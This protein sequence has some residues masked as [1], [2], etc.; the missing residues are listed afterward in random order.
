MSRPTDLFAGSEGL[1]AGGK[2]LPDP[3]LQVR[4]LILVGGLLVL[5]PELH[6]VQLGLVVHVEL[7]DARLVRLL[8]L[9]DLLATFLGSG[10]TGADRLGKT[11]PGKYHC[12][13]DN[14][15]LS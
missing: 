15:D 4:Q 5:H 9:L 3:S 12:P 14:L 6:L 2:L 11:N 1:L 7:G 13:E 10:K 8:Q